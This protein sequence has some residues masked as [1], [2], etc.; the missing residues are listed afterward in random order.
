MLCRYQCL[1]NFHTEWFLLF[2]M[3]LACC[4][5]GSDKLKKEFLAPAV[6]GEMVTAIGVSEITGGSDV[7]S[8]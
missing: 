8:E 6:A 5:F 7:A 4:R 3:L 2:P 1:A